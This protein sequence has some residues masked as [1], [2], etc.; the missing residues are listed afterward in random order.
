MGN[1]FERKVTNFERRHRNVAFGAQPGRLPI[2]GTVTRGSWSLWLFITAT[3]FSMTG[4]FIQKIAI[5]WFTWE[6]TRSSF[7]LG[8][9]AAADLLPTILLSAPAGAIVD[10]M[11]SSRALWL[12]QIAYCLATMALVALAAMGQLSI[13]GL[14]LCVA[15]RGAC[16]AFNHPA[17]FSYMT[18][19]VPPSGYGRA[20]AL[21]SL[22][23]NVGFFLGPLIGGALISATGAE[24]TFLV[25]AATYL[26]LV[27]V[28]LTIRIGAPARASKEDEDSMWAEVSGGLRYMIRSPVILPMMLSFASIAF[29]ARGIME[30]APSIVATVLHGRVEMLS[31]LNATIAAGTLAAGLCMLRWENWP[32]QAVIITTMSGCGI[33]LMGYGS[34]GTLWC[35]LPA[36]FLLG[37]MLAANS[38]CV[39]QAIQLH[40]EPHYRGRLNS[41]FNMTLKAGPAAS[42]VI[43]GWAAQRFDV[44]LATVAAA[45]ILLASLGWV[46]AMA[47][48]MPPL[49]RS[50]APA[51]I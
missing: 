35:A 41:L 34:S 50:T 22:A 16:S 15:V 36:A 11:S 7:W 24:I 27:V 43:F 37:F 18:Q 26:P 33:A 28:A 6:A 49:A 5:G 23:V 48:R 32:G 29:T 9:I 30:L 3:A 25:S 4:S 20:V 31:T 45:I 40:T 47:R 13:V 51:D 39:G 19:L 14:G 10:R 8:A 38:V 42:A 12:S 46:V 1:L 17:K 21:H 44:R 2:R